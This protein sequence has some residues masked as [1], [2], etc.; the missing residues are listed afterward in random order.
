MA[1]D[2]VRGVVTVLV[3]ITA[4]GR[5]MRRTRGKVAVVMLAIRGI[6]ITV[7]T[8]VIMNTI[9]TIRSS[10][11]WSTVVAMLTATQASLCQEGMK[12][13]VVMEGS[14]KGVLLIVSALPMKVM[15]S[16]IATTAITTTITSIPHPSN[17]ELGI[18]RKDGKAGKVEEGRSQR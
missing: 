16:L 4:R 2:M 18:E 17:R 13:I 8:L 12:R 11:S 6:A 10:S 3:L 9:N 15:P 5:G 14:K 7:A 1:G